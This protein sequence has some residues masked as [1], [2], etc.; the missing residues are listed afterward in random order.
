MAGAS[1]RGIDLASRQTTHRVEQAFPA[2]R[3]GTPFPSLVIAETSANLGA[4]GAVLSAGADGRRSQLLMML[5]LTFADAG[6]DP[7]GLN[8]GL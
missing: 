8:I 3:T 4:E 5:D 6:P 2:G 1:R 7:G